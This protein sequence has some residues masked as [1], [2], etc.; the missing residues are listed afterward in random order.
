VN[1]GHQRRSYEGVVFISRFL[2]LQTSREKATSWKRNVYFRE[3]CNHM[4]R[5]MKA[6]LDYEALVYCRLGDLY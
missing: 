1:S 3:E 6:S 5:E 4:N 2:L